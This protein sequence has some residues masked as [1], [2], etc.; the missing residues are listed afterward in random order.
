MITRPKAINLHRAIFLHSNN[1]LTGRKNK[2]GFTLLELIIVIV[3]VGILA[4]LGL[5]QYTNI[6]E[7][8]RGAD[9]KAGFGVIRKL[10]AAY[11]LLN[12]TRSGETSADIGIGSSAEQLPSSCSSR[13]YFYYTWGQ[14]SL[15]DPV[16][17]IYATRCTIGGKSP[18]SSV[19][20]QWGYRYNPLT[21]YE[22]WQCQANGS[23]KW[24]WQIRPQSCP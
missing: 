5:N 9:A 14:S 12:N 15:G 20:Y 8:S 23:V 22:D 6:V 7:A 3:I 1:P 10:H 2:N 4:V 18:P 13:S 16:I 19:S 17:Y 24:D 21:N 11:Y